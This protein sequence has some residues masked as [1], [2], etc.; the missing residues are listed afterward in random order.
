MRNGNTLK[1]LVDSLGTKVQIG[2]IIDMN[3]RYSATLTATPSDSIQFDPRGLSMDGVT[4]T[5]QIAGA[6][7]GGY[8]S[9]LVNTIGKVM[10]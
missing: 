5:V 2:T 8:D 4:T 1:I 9:L 6:I 7:A 10:R 3:A